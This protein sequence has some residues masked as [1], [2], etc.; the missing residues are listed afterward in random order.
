MSIELTQGDLLSAD[1]EALVNPVNTK[2]VMGKGLALQFKQAFPEVFREY[3][4]ACRAGVVVV[5]RMHV[6]TRGDPPRCVIHFPTK[7]H[8]REPSELSYV[9]EGLVDLV[10]Q[11]RTRGIRSIAIPP[12]G[13]GLGGLDWS[14]VQPLIV[15]AF[16]EVPDVR[17]LLFEPT[18]SAAGT[19]R[20][21]SRTRGGRLLRAATRPSPA[22]STDRSPETSRR[23]PRRPRRG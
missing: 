11:V 13:C 14:D 22:S 21:A 23:P 1:V 4:R 12:L 17:V 19:S 20:S 7:D 18:L 15:K 9:R 16:A 8:W 6:V 2:G 10:A 5:G 3:E